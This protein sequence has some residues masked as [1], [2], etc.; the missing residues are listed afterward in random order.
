MNS[1]V[2]THYYRQ[3]GIQEGKH[4][5]SASHTAVAPV[6]AAPV[7]TQTRYCERVSCQSTHEHKPW[8][9]MV[10]LLN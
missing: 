8:R 7:A 3:P 4:H 10:R 2:Y 5:L 6:S 1:T 9:W